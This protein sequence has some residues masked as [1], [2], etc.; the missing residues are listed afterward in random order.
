M[1][2]RQA[3]TTARMVTIGLALGV[4]ACGRVGYANLDA[5]AAT[6]GC[7][8]ASP[9][10]PRDGITV[11]HDGRSYVWLETGRTYTEAV[12]ACTALGGRLARI[13]DQAEHDFAWA[14]AQPN[15]MWLAGEDHAEEGVW[16]WP[17]D[18]AVFWRGLQ[19]GV[20]T[21]A[22]YTNWG[23]IEPN[24][25]GDGDGED[26]LAL[27]PAHDGRWADEACEQRSYSALCESAR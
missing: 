9:A 22:V 18:G 4:A 3:L 14:Q 21:P 5:G 24:N 19:S 8:A 26:C 27:W 6:L 25:S 11:A 16:L 2:R 17:D 15:P 7:D 10:C 20:P 12:A 1:H 23:P 13:D